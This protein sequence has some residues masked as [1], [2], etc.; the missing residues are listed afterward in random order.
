MA[1]GWE[2]HRAGE[3]WGRSQ[4]N[5]APVWSSQCSSCGGCHKGGHC[6]CAQPAP[7]P[8]AGPRA[9]HELKAA[10]QRPRTS[11]NQC[12]M[13]PCPQN[14]D[15]SLSR[16]SREQEPECE[17]VGA[18]VPGARGCSALLRPQRDT[19]HRSAS[20]N[21]TFSPF[22]TTVPPFFSLFWLS[23]GWEGDEEGA[24]PAQVHERCPG[25]WSTKWHRKQSH[26]SL[27]LPGCRSGAEGCIPSW[28]KSAASWM[29][30]N[31]AL[32]RQK[33]HFSLPF[34]PLLFANP[35]FPPCIIFSA[36][37]CLAASPGFASVSFDCSLLPWLPEIPL[38]SSWSFQARRPCV[39]AKPCVLRVGQ[40]EYLGIK[41][42]F[43]PGNNVPD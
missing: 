18:F 16:S 23:R 29:S 8:R 43:L 11:S 12:R 5:T 30:G 35:P 15:D 22:P 20:L 33:K 24:E 21:G 19:C 28:N 32:E 14:R 36:P 10:G 17:R 13:S 39:P 37:S 27:W 25:F 2:S 31:S 1:E 3:S 4:G 7:A 38:C 41:Q 6:S 40:G 26:G 42:S 9:L 34:S